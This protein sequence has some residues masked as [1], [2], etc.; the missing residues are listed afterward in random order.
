MLKNMFN[1]D[2]TMTIS[3]ENR[4]YN[5]SYL[6]ISIYISFSFEESSQRFTM[7]NTTLSS[8]YY[9]GI[10]LLYYFM[11]YILLQIKVYF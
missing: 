6:S 11:T 8:F 7:Q 9:S 2:F 1:I 4:I 10:H 3:K 5:Q